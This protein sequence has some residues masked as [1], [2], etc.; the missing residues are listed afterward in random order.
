MS[1]DT[2]LTDDRGRPFVK[3]DPADYA[4]A[5]DFMRAYHA[6]RDAVSDAANRAFDEGFRKAMRRTR[7]TLAQ[8]NG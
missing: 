1:N 2:I 7:K 3:P 8:L 5:V 6:Y 4:N